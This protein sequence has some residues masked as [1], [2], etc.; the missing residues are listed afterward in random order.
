MKRTA[1]ALFFGLLLPAAAG[2][3][4]AVVHADGDA[5]VTASE[6]ASKQYTLNQN[7]DVV[8]LAP[9]GAAPRKVVLLTFDDGPKN[10]NTLTSLLD[11]LDRHGAKAIF[12][13]NGSR[14]QK[15]P[16]LLKLIHERKQTIGNHSWDHINLKNAP[17][18]TVQSQINGVQQLVLELTGEAPRF[19]RPPHGSGSDVVRVRV[20]EEN[21]LYMT[22]S[23]GSLDWSAETNDKPA[24]VIANV[25]KQLRPGSNIL[26]HELPWTAEALDPLLTELERLGYGFVDPASI[27]T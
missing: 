26:M 15:N 21:M 24:E 8:P 16:E 4:P 22:W 19:F 3:S 12:F 20:R 18:E 14:A 13:I 6:T 7:F 10:R 23:N 17:A 1:V 9:S 2:F 25:L 27:E 5:P 11:T